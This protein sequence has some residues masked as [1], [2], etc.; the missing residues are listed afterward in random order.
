[1]H[2]SSWGVFGHDSP[3]LLQEKKRKPDW[4][5]RTLL[6]GGDKYTAIKAKLRELKLHTVCEEA[7]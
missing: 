4:M 3:I 1:M 2:I 5:K 6:P 7:K